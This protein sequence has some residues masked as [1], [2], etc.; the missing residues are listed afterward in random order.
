MTTTPTPD[1]DAATDATTTADTR[2]QQ[3]A[4][5]EFAGQQPASVSFDDKDGRDDAMEQK[6]AEWVD[7]LVEAAENARESVVFSQ[8]MDTKAALHDYSRRNSMLI[9]MQKPGA[10]HV[11][12][13]HTWQNEFGRSVKK[14]ENAIWIWRPNTVTSHKCPEC[15]NAPSYH[16]W[17][18]H[19]N[20]SRAGTDPDSW[21]IDPTDEWERGEILCGFSPA[22]VFALEQTEPMD[23]EE[24]VDAEAF[25]LPTETTGEVATDLLDAVIQAGRD[26]FEWEVDTVEP[27]EW[28]RRGNGYCTTMG[29]PTIRAKHDTDADTVEV[30]AHEYAHALLHVEQADDSERDARELEAEAVG[31]I[32]ARHFGLNADNSAFYLASWTNDDGHADPD[33][34]S[35][36]LDR[37]SNTASKIIEAVT[38]HRDE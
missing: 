37:I 7:E 10:A 4:A 8:W 2:P 30:L 1:A 35:D 25:E 27:E 33:E 32:V 38:D 28:N 26:T 3:T 31:Y 34:I 21:D 19:L 20:C 23:D 15:G 12:G 5:G 6:M 36:R 13:F 22:P 11:A 17:N 16:E 14:G 24:S 18:D 9:Q 29:T